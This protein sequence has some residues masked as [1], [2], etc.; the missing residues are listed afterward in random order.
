M[1]VDRAAPEAIQGTQLDLAELRQKQLSVLAL[2][3]MALAGGVSWAILPGTGFRVLRFL[4]FFSL[5]AE[6]GL[7]YC[8]RAR[9][10]RV[11]QTVL[12]VGP[13]LSLALALRAFTTPTVPCFAVLIVI[14][15]GS[16]QPLWGLAAALLGSIPLL[17]LLP[18]SELQLASLAL[19]WLTA[20]TEWLSARGLYT[21]LQWAWN[22]QQRANRLLEQL[23]GQQGRLNQTVVALTEATRRLQHTGH[24]LVVARLRAE[25]ARQLKEQFAANISHELR[26][27]L[28]LILGFSEMMYLTPDVYGKMT[29]PVTLRRDVQQVYQS[30]RQLLDLV[31]DVLDLA[32]V[33][34]A[35]LPVQ[36]EPSDLR[37][38]VREAVETARDLVRGR[39]LEISAQLPPAIP[40]LSLDR[41]RIRQVLLNLLNNAIRFTPRGAITVG[42][43]SDGREVVVSVADAGVG[44]P[45]EQLGRIFEEFYQ[46]D[47]SLRRPS[48]GAGLGLAI[49][50][51]FV[52]LH[53]GRIW[54]ESE[55]GK[56]STFHFSLPLTAESAVAP[57]LPGRAVEPQES[58]ERPTLLL[59]DRDPGVGAVLARYLTQH[60]IRQVE[61][62]EQARR[63][64]D[65][66]HPSA[67]LLNLPPDDEA[68][69]AVRR[70]ALSLLPPDLPLLLCSLPSQT[71]LALETRVHGCLEKPIA[72]EQL[73]AS[74]EGLNG[75]RDILVIDDDVGFCQLVIRFLESE[76]GRYTVRWA[77]DGKEALAQIRERAPQAILL[78]LAMPVMDGFQ[79]LEALRSVEGASAIPVL[80]VTGAG[81]SHDM[82]AERGST[83]AIAQR[84]GFRA[85]QVIHYLQALLE[86]RGVRPG[87]GAPV[88]ARAAP[89][90]P[91][92][93]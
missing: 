55:V 29:W 41:T 87:G 4:V 39:D 74:L 75:A 51:R 60:N 77:C 8:F 90:A 63:L 83:V 93:R 9:C 61:S 11:T 44:I 59:V 24:E 16:I 81:Y 92:W 69:H 26:T 45:P 82:L 85:T 56:G 20:G 33:D 65:D 15:N 13:C 47:M 50:K 43:Q 78:D 10:P 27:P 76:S 53:G 48:G 23:R 79:F 22:S 6:G 84:P 17:L 12:L 25:E 21:A 34:A 86:A 68:W 49:S 1:A 2:A 38:V 28:N 52:E 67:V 32:R 91:A 64:L 14:A 73:L 62:L 30:S 88:P 36:K 18:Q 35:E 40:L 71:W 46:V 37:Q 5:F 19:V 31:N 54:A 80:L 66:W 7:A 42:V 58:E 72:R 70:Q 57:L 89:A 3:L